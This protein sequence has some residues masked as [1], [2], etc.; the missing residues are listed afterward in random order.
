MP[1]SR[2]IAGLTVRG[3]RRAERMR[4]A[5]PDSG[6]VLDRGGGGGLPAPW[7]VMPGEVILRVTDQSHGTGPAGAEYRA[8]ARS[9]EKLKTG[10][11]YVDVLR[12]GVVE[13]VTVPAA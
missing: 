7:E 12:K 10:G 3:L 9:M 5:L 6:G 1:E 13:A 8:F 11:G 2:V 4:L